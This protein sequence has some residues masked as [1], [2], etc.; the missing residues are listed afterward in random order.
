MSLLPSSHELLISP[1][2]LRML[3]SIKDKRCDD[4]L[5]GECQ[6]EQELLKETE[7][8]FPDCEMCFKLCFTYTTFP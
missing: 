7:G 2:L 5:K 6:E 3:N 1:T 4:V 8:Q